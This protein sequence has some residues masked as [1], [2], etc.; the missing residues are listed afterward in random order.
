MISKLK[1]NLKTDRKLGSRF[2]A[3]LKKMPKKGSSN[4]NLD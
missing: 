4:F 2:S 1:R 3:L